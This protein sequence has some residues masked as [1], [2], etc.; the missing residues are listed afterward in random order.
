[1]EEN[2]TVVGFWKGRKDVGGGVRSINVA[3][4][5][6]LKCVVDKLMSALGIYNARSS[7]R[8]YVVDGLSTDRHIIKIRHRFMCSKAWVDAMD[9][10]L[11]R[12]HGW[13]RR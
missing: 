3:K 6:P 11:W 9:F 2:T 13:Y 4:E 1:M 8:Q 12:K 7:F 10:R 5:V